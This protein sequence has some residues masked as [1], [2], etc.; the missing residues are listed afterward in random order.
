MRDGNC[1][2]GECDGTAQ[3]QGVPG[4]PPDKPSRSPRRVPSKRGG[5][6]LPVRE[7]FL[8]TRTS[9]ITPVTTSVQAESAEPQGAGLSASCQPY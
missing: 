8:L 9:W 1:L 7:D 3:E 2:F 5:H 6:G 4:F